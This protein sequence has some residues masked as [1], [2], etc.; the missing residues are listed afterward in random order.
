MPWKGQTDMPMS[1]VATSTP[2][3][4]LIDGNLRIGPR[5]VPLEAGIECSS[6]CG[7]SSR[8][9]AED[10]PIDRWYF[11]RNMPIQIADHA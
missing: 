3:Y 4:V 10:G 5:F 6:I 2:N 9:L 1:T 11:V 7:F 8:V